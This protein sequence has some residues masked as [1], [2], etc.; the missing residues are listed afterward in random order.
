MFL[1]KQWR[2]IYKL[3]ITIM[4]M[5]KIIIAIHPLRERDNYSDPYEWDK[6]YSHHRLLV[7]IFIKNHL[8][9]DE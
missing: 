6:K 9:A 7:L 5:H 8:D 4:Q 1:F 2:A 3:S